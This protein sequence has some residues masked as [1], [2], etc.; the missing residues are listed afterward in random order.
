MSSFVLGFSPIHL[1]ILYKGKISGTTISGTDGIKGKHFE[2]NLASNCSEISQGIRDATYSFRPYKEKLILKGRNKNPRIISIPTVRDRLVLR[3]IF[4]LLRTEFKEETEQVRPQKIVSN[5]K[6]VDEKSFKNVTRIDLKDFYGTI[7][8]RILKK[9]LATKIK[10][11][12]VLK[13]IMSA[14][15]TPT[16]TAGENSKDAT[17]VVRGVPQGLSISNCLA[18]I[19]LSDFDSHFKHKASYEFF[20]YVDDILIFCNS[21]NTDQTFQT[22]E[23]LLSEIKLRA[24]KP[25]KSGAKT[26]ISSSTDTFEY[27]GYLIEKPDI[28]VKKSS[29]IKMYEALQKIITQHRY[30]DRPDKDILVW[31]TNLRITGCIFEGKRR[32]WL[33]YFSQISEQNRTQL[34][35]LDMKIR[36][37]L[38]PY[39]DETKLKSIKRLSRAYY[40]IN[41]R[42]RT[43][44]Y[45]PNFD[46]YTI[47]DMEYVLERIYK[48]PNLYKKSDEDVRKI[49]KSKIG[50]T[51]R[52]L[53]KDAEPFYP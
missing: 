44:K 14:I 47:D 22:C 53:E 18:A 17:K 3:A 7:N 1:L 32:G 41:K 50:I 36:K 6:K 40:E 35:S 29:Y 28:I 38:A 15:S 30:H 43:T 11:K 37:F 34:F 4:E 48:I 25:T 2:Q 13:L 24:H 39:L 42:F 46:D 20:R 31:R 52:D 19:Y 23:A 51:I 16:V 27:L 8:H 21:D 45:I 26:K 9:K 5:I 49:F 10:Q 12:H 33:F